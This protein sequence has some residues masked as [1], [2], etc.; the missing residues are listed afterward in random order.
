MFPGGGYGIPTSTPSAR[1]RSRRCASAARGLPVVIVN[2][3]FVFGSRRHLPLLDR[4]RP[5]LP[6][7]EIPAYV[8]GAL[9]IVDAED[10]AR[11]HL[12]A[13]E[14]GT[15]GERYILGNRNFT[16]DRLFADLGRLSGVE[17]PALKLPL[18]VAL[19]SRASAQSVPGQPADDRGRGRAGVAVVGVS[20]HQ[21]QARA[22]L[23]T[24][25]TTRTHCQ[26]RSTG[27]ASTS[28][29]SPRPARASRWRCASPGSPCAS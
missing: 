18:G 23:E 5:A 24:P 12:L 13:D 19:R 6:A 9:N 15:V 3:A 20:L 21:G 2:P 17:P 7:R 25:P 29:A 8:D 10:V 28:S 14:R 1:P 4:D 11:G 22:G 26:R 16:L 27:T